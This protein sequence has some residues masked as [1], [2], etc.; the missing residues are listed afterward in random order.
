MK[1]EDMPRLAD[2]IARVLVKGE[3]PVSVRHDTIALRKS[4]TQLHYIH[5]Q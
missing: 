5:Q 2:L 4:F 1:E 3:D